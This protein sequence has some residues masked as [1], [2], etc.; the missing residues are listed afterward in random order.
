[1]EES[2]SVV[3]TVLVNSLAG[4]L[5]VTEVSHLHIRAG[6]KH[7]ILDSKHNRE[8]ESAKLSPKNSWLLIETI[9][10][11]ISNING[12]IKIIC[13]YTESWNPEDN[14]WKPLFWVCL[15]NLLSYFPVMESFWKYKLFCFNN[16]PVVCHEICE[17]IHQDEEGILKPLCRSKI[18]IFRLQRIHLDFFSRL[19]DF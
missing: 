18:S 5:P 4:C 19:R 7:V 16:F 3:W 10:N 2:S 8:K 13:W 15:V 17:F 11:N 6:E 12:W 1:M 9:A 14:V